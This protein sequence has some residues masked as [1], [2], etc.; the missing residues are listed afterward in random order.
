MKRIAIASAGLSTLFFASTANAEPSEGP[1][2]PQLSQTVAEF[3][4]ESGY[5]PEDGPVRVNLQATARQNI[6]V[7]M[8]GAAYYDWDNQG[9]IFRGEPEGGLFV[10]TVQAEITATV[11]L[12]VLGLQGEVE[13]GIWDL[14]EQI[15]QQ[16]TPYILAGNADAPIE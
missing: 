15:E 14:E 16:F 2:A 12:D 7:T 11:A 3:P 10:N 9:L 8:P 5:L 4:W 6:D 1:F 13:V